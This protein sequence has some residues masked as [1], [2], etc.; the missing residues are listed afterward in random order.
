VLILHHL[1]LQSESQKGNNRSEDIK[2]FL[3]Q[4]ETVRGFLGSWRSVVWAGNI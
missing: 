1:A 2:D 3:T 4:Q